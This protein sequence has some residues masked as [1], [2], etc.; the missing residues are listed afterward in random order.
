MA[1]PYDATG[2]DLIELAP[3]GWLE[4]LG[5]SRPPERV[6][7]V[8][9]E[10]STVTAAADKVIRV[11]DDPPW[12]LHIE[13]QADWDETLPARSLMYNAIPHARHQVAVSSVVFLLRPAANARVI[14]GRLRMAPPFGPPWEFRYT[15][16]R[17][18]E[19]S[20]ATLVAGPLPLLPLAPAVGA[21]PG[22]LVGVIGRMKERIDREADRAA[23]AKLWMV[24]YILMGFRYEAPLVNALL[25]GVITMEDSTTYQYILDRGREA[26]LHQGRI[27]EAR[28][29]ILRQGRKLF[30]SPPPA[31]VESAFNRITELA[32]L[33]ALG[34]RLSDVS[35][36]DELLTN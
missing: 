20:A 9:A 18:W 29:L 33:E 35:S 34:E 13:F 32:R 36:W 23:A 15:V 6:S 8:D 11:E 28:A 5:V 31:D 27:E 10:V 19:L 24:T 30:R 25:S 16:I 17:V 22:E 14:T 4:F 3:A 21:T 12:L 2:K 7:V 26:G 1:R